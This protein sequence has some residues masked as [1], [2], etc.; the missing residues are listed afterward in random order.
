MKPLSKK[1]PNRAIF[2]LSLKSFPKRIGT[3]TATFV[4]TAITFFVYF[5]T[6][7]AGLFSFLT[8]I[9]EGSSVS[10][11]TITPLN[12]TSAQTMDLLRAA[13]NFDPNPN[14]SANI[15]PIAD[16][17]LIP[18]IAASNDG[19]SDQNSTQINT[20]TVRDGDSV[21]GIAKMFHV[22][23]N[24][25]LWANGL[26]SKSVLKTGQSL[27]ILPVSGIMY[28][29]KKNDTISSIANK[30]GADTQDITS[31][32]DLSVNTLTVGQSIIIP[33]AEIG[34]PQ[35][36]VTR[37]VVGN[38]R[39]LDNVSA[40][41]SY[42]GYYARPIAIGRI[43]QGLHGHNAI[44][45]AAPV[46]TPIYASAAGVV[47]I[48]RINGAWNGGY[49][50]FVVISHNNGTQTLYAHMQSKTF[51]VPGEQVVQGQVIGHIGMTGLTTGP[52]V[53]FEIRGAK[54]PFQ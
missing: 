46:G 18:D 27:V 44:D 40:L 50:N 38:E 49:G 41:P 43:S 6:A 13:T 19:S 23:I 17:A 42:P 48:S 37:V 53:H 14:K 5:G 8:P 52:H 30:Y 15:A 1:R 47:I 26:T 34:A 22:S 45:F 3:L 4:L 51:V 54:N 29:V 25:V 12:T 31:F 33:N 21:S 32:N 28:T 2:Y 9:I 35:S 24:T 39:L 36:T 16:N 20:Y 10:A 11:Q 7:N